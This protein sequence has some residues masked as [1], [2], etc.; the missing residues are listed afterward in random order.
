MMEENRG[1]WAYLL[2]EHG[3]KLLGLLGGFITS[4]LIIYLGFIYTVFIVSLSAL[5]YYIGSR[6]DNRESLRD[7]L[8]RILPPRG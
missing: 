6:L 7:L 4:L 1:L 5:G 3:G 2:G 8:N